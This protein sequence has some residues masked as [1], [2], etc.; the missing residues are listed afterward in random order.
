MLKFVIDEDMPRSTATILKT[1]SYEALDV[2]VAVS[3]LFKWS[4]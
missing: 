1:R 2:E 3:I 4:F